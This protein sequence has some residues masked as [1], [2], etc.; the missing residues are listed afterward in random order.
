MDIQFVFNETDNYKKLLYRIIYNKFNIKNISEI[1]SE[2]QLLLL[3]DF[4]DIN[5]N[6]INIFNETKKNEIY[7][8][9]E[10]D[11]FL[12]IKK[13]P[14]FVLFPSKYLE[15]IKFMTNKNI[16]DFFIKEKNNSINLNYEI[17]DTKTIQNDDIKDLLKY[18]INYSNNYNQFLLTLKL[19]NIDVYN[20]L[21]KYLLN[22]A[23]IC[24]VFQLKELKEFLSIQRFLNLIFKNLRVL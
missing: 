17:I 8:D 22:D 13:N 11:I 18:Y 10:N 5:P 14:K 9:G 6:I 4:I 1:K 20:F 21:I 15:N 3:D 7:L 2:C 23:P 19:T 16:F 24:F 12:T